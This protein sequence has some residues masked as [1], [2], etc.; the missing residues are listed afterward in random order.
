M[1]KEKPNWKTTPPRRALSGRDTSVRDIHEPFWLKFCPCIHTL[2]YARQPVIHGSESHREGGVKD[3]TT[4]HKLRYF[5]IDLTHVYITDDTVQREEGP[6]SRKTDAHVLKDSPFT[7]PEAGRAS[8]SRCRC[9]R[10]RPCPTIRGVRLHRGTA[11]R[12]RERWHP[13]P[14]RD[15]LR[16]SG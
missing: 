12:R 11:L 14:C 9:R 4:R 6:D 2:Y 15:R 1:R 13:R 16:A 7:R 8:A 3:T 10:A 5:P